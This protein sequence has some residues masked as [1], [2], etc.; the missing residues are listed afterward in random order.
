MTDR[1]QTTIIVGRW[2]AVGV[3]SLLTVPTLIVWVEGL[4]HVI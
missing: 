1:S 2:L 3:L 4:V